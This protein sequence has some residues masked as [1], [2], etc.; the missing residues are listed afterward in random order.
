MVVTPQRYSWSRSCLT[1]IMSLVIF[2]VFLNW[3][4][5]NEDVRILKIK[6]PADNA[7]SPF[8]ISRDAEQAYGFWKW[9]T[10]IRQIREDSCNQPDE[11]IWINLG[12]T[13]RYLTHRNSGS[14]NGWE[15]VG[16]RAWWKNWPGVG[17]E[18]KEIWPRK[19]EKTDINNGS[20]KYVLD[21]SI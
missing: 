2:Y 16:F 21:D 7:P 8:R 11:H 19:R 17:C 3:I 4:A 13:A 12:C 1:W 9:Y 20:A 5:N 18:K 14:A 15:M 6:R 10:I